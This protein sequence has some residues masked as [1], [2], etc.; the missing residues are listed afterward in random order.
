MAAADALVDFRQSREDGEQRK[1]KSKDKGKRKEWEGKKFQPKGKPNNNK[2]KSIVTE[3]HPYRSNS[4]CFICNGPH[5]AKDCSKKEKLNAMSTAG[6]EQKNDDGDTQVRMNPL[7]VRLNAL[8][9]EATTEL[10]FVPIEANSQRTSAMLDTG[11]THNFVAAHMVEKLGLKV[12][13]CPNQLKAVNSEAQ[14]VIGMAHAVSLRVGDWTGKVTFLVVPLDDFDI[15]LGNAFFVLAKAVPM[16]FLGGLLIMDEEQPCFVK[17]TKKDVGECSKKKGFISAMQLKDGLRRRE[18]TYLAALREVKKR[19]A[20][21]VPEK[22]AELLMEFRD[23]M[24]AELPK[25][26]PPR[27]A[28]DHKIELM[29]GSIPPAR[30]PYRMSPKE[31]VELQNQLT[32]LLEA[33]FVQ[34]SKAPYGA[35]VLFQKKKDRALRMCIDYRALNKVTV[36]NKYP[37]PLIQ[38]LF[39]RLCKAAYFSKLDLRSGYWQ[40]RIAEG[41]EPKTTCVTRYGSF[42]FLVMPFGLTNAPAT[43]CNLMNNVFHDYIDKFVVVYLDDIVVYS[44]SFDDHLCHLRLVLSRLRENSLYVKEEKCDFARKDI[45][46]LGHRISLGKILMD[47]GKVK[48]IHDWPPP[49]TVS[50][51]RSFLGLANY[52]RKFIAAYA[53]K[54]APLTDLLKKET[55][56][57]WS[58]QCKA[59]FE[60]LKLAVASEPVLHLPNFELPFEV[61]TDASDRVIGGVLVQ[62]GHP[63]AYESRKLKEAEHRYSAHEKEMLAVI[64]CL[65]VWRVYLLGAQFVARTDNASNTYFHSQKKLSPKQA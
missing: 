45:L 21:E 11:A 39:D 56:W 46:F 40:V 38:D 6:V 33:G 41:D 28:V 44:E 26:L 14:P 64:H 30:A 25:T 5:R 2:G 42:E 27:R 18:V 7:Q 61:H 9:S 3:K 17:A 57:C 60:K 50:E 15:I 59:A 48:A 4:G 55:K 54:A 1:P 16:P 23:V 36:K 20:V 35:P 29:P 12:G 8:K 58:D 22:V 37:V 53:K 34:P 32:E 65:L 24:P 49:K 47:D 31:L 43:F 19:D 63:V 10:L 13:N 52:Y 62:E 51:L